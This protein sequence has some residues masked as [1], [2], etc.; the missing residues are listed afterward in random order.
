MPNGNNSATSGT[1]GAVEVNNLVLWKSRDVVLHSEEDHSLCWGQEE[2]KG[3][4]V[5]CKS[6]QRQKL[7]LQPDDQKRWDKRECIMFL[8]KNVK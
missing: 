5:S 7:N 1:P 8:L 4:K 2:A 6:D 3:P